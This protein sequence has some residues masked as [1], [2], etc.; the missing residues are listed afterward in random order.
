[1]E[2]RQASSVASSGIWNKVSVRA[3]STEASVE[4]RGV[5]ERCISGALSKNFEMGKVF[6]V[7]PIERWHRLF[8]FFKPSQ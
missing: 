3:V 1:M 4:T 6:L 7:L 2:E 8:F 5:K